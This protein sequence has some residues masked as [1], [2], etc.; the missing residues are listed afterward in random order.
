MKRIP[1]LG[2]HSEEAMCTSENATVMLDDKRYSQSNCAKD[3]ARKKTRLQGME[4]NFVGTC[5][6]E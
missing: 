2:V 4:K 3:D 5:T 6:S 1:W